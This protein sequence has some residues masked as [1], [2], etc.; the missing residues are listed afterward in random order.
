MV[1]NPWAWVVREDALIS[2]CCCY[3]SHGPGGLNNSLFPTVLEAEVQDQGACTVG[4]F[5]RA[6]S[7]VLASHGVFL[8]C[9]LGAERERVKERERDQVF[10]F[11]YKGINPIMGTPPL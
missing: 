11:F 9:I 1:S 3:K 4:L 6:L 7:L 5:V 8:V 10:S 2:S